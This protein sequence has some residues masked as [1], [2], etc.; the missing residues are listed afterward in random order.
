M[1]QWKQNLITTIIAS[2]IV[3]IVFI[4]WIST[5]S[6]RPLWEIDKHELKKLNLADSYAVTA[7]TTIDKTQITDADFGIICGSLEV[8]L[9]QIVN[10]NDYIIKEVLI[11][12]GNTRYYLQAQ[13]KR[14]ELIAVE[15]NGVYRVHKIRTTN[16]GVMGFRGQT[17]SQNFDDV[18]LLFN[19]TLSK[20]S[21]IKIYNKDKTKLMQ[22]QFRSGILCEI[23]IEY[24]VK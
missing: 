13:S 11:I 17:I 1:S 2:F 4:I 24:N 5:G 21:K 6:F 8:L 23:A 7:D 18:N 9:G 15:M 3:L 16:I 14:Y 19:N 20:H 10:P 12:D 22:M